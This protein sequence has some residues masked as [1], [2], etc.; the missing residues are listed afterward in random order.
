MANIS[1]SESFEAGIYRIETTD[2]VGGGENG[3]DN[4]PH[5]QLANRTKYLK[6]IADEV[7]TAR[8]ASASLG[9]RLDE[10]E[11]LDAETQNALM[12]AAAAGLSLAGL[13]NK[14]VEK[15]RTKRKQTGLA[16]ITN[17]GIITGC[18][19]SKATGSSRNLDCASG[20]VF[21]GGQIFP[22]FAVGAGAIVPPNTDIVSKTCYAFLYLDTNKVVQFASTGFGETV[23]DGAIPLYLIT[24]P[25]NNTDINDPNLTLVTLTDIRRVEPNF[26]VFFA[27]A[28]YA[29][30][31]LPFPVTE[32]DYAIT[33]DLVSILGS[34]FQR[35]D[36]Y[37]GDRNV[38][39]FKIYYNGVSDSLSVRW[40]ISKPNL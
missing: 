19:V 7:V 32:A 4:L 39:G 34:G 17:R 10:F 6:R 36:V 8:G 22:M 30:V 1:E 15:S 21:S 23:P 31:V 13:A 33:L 2:P 14:E 16:T 3:I 37:P 38:N 26:P 9:D 27:S 11:P 20:S 25:A 24:V 35:G 28:P 29:D 12:A 5:K 18:T 40:E